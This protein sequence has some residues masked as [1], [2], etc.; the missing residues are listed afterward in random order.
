LPIRGSKGGILRFLDKRQIYDIHLAVLEILERVGIQVETRR[1][2]EVFK[3]GGAEVDFEAKRVKIQ[4]HLVEEAV[5]K[6]PKKVVLMGRKREN[7]VILGND[8]ICFGLGG[9][10]KSRILD[11]ES[12]VLRE[13]KKKDVEDGT[14]LGDALPSI[15]F[16]QNFAQAMDVPKQVQYYHVAEAMFNNSEKHL[17]ITA[18][19]AEEAE[20]VIKMA[21]FVEE[22]FGRKPISMYGGPASPLMLTASQENLIVA[23]ENGVPI[24]LC[25]APMAGATAPVTLPGLVAQNLAENLSAL[26]LSQLVRP[27]IPVVLGSTVTIMDPRTGSFSLG[28]PEGMIAQVMSAQMSHYYGLPY[29]GYGCCSDSKTFDVQAAAEAA[30]NGLMAALGGVNMIQDVGVINLDDAG[31][32]ELAVLSEEITGIIQRILQGS[33]VDDDSLALDVIADVGPGGY[34]L[35]HRHTLKYLSREIY[36]PKLFDRRSMME[37]VRDGSK[38]LREIAREKAKKIL[39]DHLPEPLSNDIKEKL[40]ELV[41]EAERKTLA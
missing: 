36:I 40:H 22:A 33:P 5:R 25:N 2:M 41:L 16:I 39:R 34:F 9:S 31:C 21:G 35:S 7:D 30:M 10:P 3:D 29:F 8:R 26:V 23:A 24:V 37:W 32:F 18:P 19:S 27:S 15:S 11:L 12:G 6:A 28:S 4:Q 14:R 17:L 1:M 38:D 20:P 13:P